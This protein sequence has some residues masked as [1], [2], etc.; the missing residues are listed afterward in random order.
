MAKLFYQIK[1]N[2]FVVVML[3]FA[4]SGKTDDWNTSICKNQ[5][6][7]N[8]TIDFQ[9][10]FVND[11]IE[12]RLNGKRIYSKNNCNTS[13]LTGLAESVSLKVGNCSNKIK[14]IIINRDIE[15]EIRL[16]VEDDVFIGI[17][18][19]NDTIEHIVSTKPFGYG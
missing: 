17:S 16:E 19:V 14:V 3:L 15:K 1:K 10:G 9:D 4:L 6:M 5:N 11:S 18:I 2:L 7:A 13:R 12:C 8:L